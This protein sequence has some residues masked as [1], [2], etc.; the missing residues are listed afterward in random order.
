MSSIFIVGLV[1]VGL[2]VILAAASLAAFYSYFLSFCLSLC[3]YFLDNFLEDSLLFWG[4]LS[5]SW[6][7]REAFL[8]ATLSDFWLFF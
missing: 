6:T 3:L 7:S 4:E 8:G 1:I 2:E 5:S